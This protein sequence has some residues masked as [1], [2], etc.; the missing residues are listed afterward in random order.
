VMPIDLPRVTGKTLIQD[1]PAGE[2]LK[3]T[4]LTGVE[5]AR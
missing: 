2:Y 4:M 5:G 1:L 3:W